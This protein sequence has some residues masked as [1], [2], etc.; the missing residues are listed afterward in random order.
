MNHLNNFLGINNAIMPQITSVTQQIEGLNNMM[1][2]TSTLEQSNEA[3]QTDITYTTPDG[4]LSI[5]YPASFT[6]GR[7]IMENLLGKNFDA[8]NYL[9]Y[10]Y[11][12]NSVFDMQPQ[13]LIITHY[14]ATSTEE[15][16]DQIKK[17]LNQQG[18]QG[19]INEAAIEEI[20]NYPL[21]IFDSN[22]KC[23]DQGD[24]SAWQ[25]R[26]AIIKKMTRNFI[27]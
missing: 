13:T 18:C 12:I 20:S 10:I 11:K 24:L 2:S 9:L 5:S 6:D 27:Q 19:E 14:D 15:V 26:V 23:G 25:A 8:N 16:A 3:K 7:K 1:A 4:Y 21:R 22:Y 17:A